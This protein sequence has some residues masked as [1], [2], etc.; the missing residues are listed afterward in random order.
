MLTAKGKYG[1]KALL[2]LARLE[3]GELAQTSEIA[4][5]NNIPEKF[6]NAILGDLR[7]AGFVRTKKGRGGGVCL[8]KPAGEIFIG[9]VLRLLDG[10]LGP[11]SCASFSAYRPCADCL[12]VSR[13]AVRLLMLEVRNATAAILDT[14]S[15]AEMANPDEAASMADGAVLEAF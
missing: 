8:G 14:C 2:H 15:L 5:R 12:D 1:L 7:K 11:M 10:P 9:S 6:L 3:P 13:C 4:S